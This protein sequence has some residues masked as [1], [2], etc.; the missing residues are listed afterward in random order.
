MGQGP[1][2]ATEGKIIMAM[3]NA[4]RFAKF[5]KDKTRVFFPTRDIDNLDRLCGYYGLR[6][7]ELLE[8][9]VHNVFVYAACDYDNAYQDDLFHGEPPFD[10][11]KPRFP[12]IA[13]PRG[14]LRLISTVNPKENLY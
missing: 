5:S 12:V 4:E 3:T 2:I 6:R 14:K 1:H 11:K 9:A 10:G 13:K 7:E 8:L